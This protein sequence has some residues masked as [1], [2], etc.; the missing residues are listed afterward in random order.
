M[1]FIISGCGNTKTKDSDADFPGRET[2]AA[3]SYHSAALKKDGTVVTTKGPDNKNLNAGQ[4]DVSDWKD[5]VSLACSARQT[6]GLKKDGT[7]VAAGYNGDGQ[8]DVD[9]WTGIDVP[10]H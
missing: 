4:C 5:I 7:V 3:G 2:I 1:A 9:D 8:T 6:I 10:K